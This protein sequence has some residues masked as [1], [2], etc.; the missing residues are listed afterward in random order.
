MIKQRSRIVLVKFLLLIFLYFASF[1]VMTCPQDGFAQELK[2]YHNNAVDC[3]QEAPQSIDPIKMTSGISESKLN[4]VSAPIMHFIRTLHI[5]N[6]AFTCFTGTT[7][8]IK[9]DVTVQTQV[10]GSLYGPEFIPDKTTFK[11]TECSTDIDGNFR[12]CDSRQIPNRKDNLTN[13]FELGVPSPPINLN[14]VSLNS[15][16]SKWITAKDFTYSCSSSAQR[17]EIKL[18]EVTLFTSYFENSNSSGNSFMATTCIRDTKTA[19]IDS[20]YISLQ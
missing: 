2:P 10:F 19:T 9:F 8:G 1:G 13:C 18:K 4:E 20:C 16:L 14:A 17:G 3:S 7:P 15:S 6:N 12:S 11:L 5:D